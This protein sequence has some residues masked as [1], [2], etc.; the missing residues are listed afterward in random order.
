MLKGELSST[1]L[2]P[3]RYWPSVSF[4]AALSQFFNAWCCC[5][6]S[7]TAGFVV[8]WLVL[9]KPSSLADWHSTTEIGGTIPDLVGWKSSG[10]WPVAGR[11]AM[12][13]GWGYVIMPLDPAWC[14]GYILTDGW[15][16][17]IF[18]VMCWG[19]C[20]CNGFEAL[21]SKLYRTEV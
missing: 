17:G 2:L 18:F 14:E 12:S 20:G 8:I 11:H 19:A 16:T 10:P 21:L 9:G 1:W 15:A 5:V 3:R 7:N 6:I 13:W 4:I